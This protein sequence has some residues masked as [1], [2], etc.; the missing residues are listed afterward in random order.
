MQIIRNVVHATVCAMFEY[1]LYLSNLTMH[2]NKWLVLNFICGMDNLTIIFMRM[3]HYSGYNFATI[4]IIFRAT[5]KITI[6]HHI[7]IFSSYV[8]SQT[9]VD[10]GHV[11]F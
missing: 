10:C 7:I 6:N 1:K 4:N 5:N 3:S 11:E 8:L 9:K 2:T